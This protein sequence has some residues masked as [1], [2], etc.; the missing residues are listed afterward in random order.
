MCCSAKSKILAKKA[1][2]VPDRAMVL[3]LKR[4]SV[5]I[6]IAAAN[7]SH[8]YGY[9][10]TDLTLWLVAAIAFHQCRIGW[11]VAC[12]DV[13]QMNVA[14]GSNCEELKQGTHFRIAANNRHR[15]AERKRSSPSLCRQAVASCFW[16]D[17]FRLFGK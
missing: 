2:G 3:R 4:Y 12:G 5:N 11:D 1:G 17:R 14:F 8:G 16:S 6:T 15:A 13:A 7:K 10:N 9:Q